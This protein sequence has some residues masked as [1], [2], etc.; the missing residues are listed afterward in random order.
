MCQTTIDHHSHNLEAL[1]MLCQRIDPLKYRHI[2]P[3][4]NGGSAGGHLRHCIEFYRCFLAGLESGQINYDARQRD[5][6]IEAEPHAAAAA[7]GEIRH[8]MDSIGERL[9]PAQKLM[10]RE[11]GEAW[12]TSTFERESRFL[13]SHTV[14]HMALI[15]VLLRA[16]GVSIPAD[17][18]V[19]PSTLKHRKEVAEDHPSRA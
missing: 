2:C 13:I 19:A 5:P 10:V 12:L 6:A 7:L 8:A 9:L 15:A 11:C 3:K 4:L 18:G 17:F 14:H 1:M 16:E